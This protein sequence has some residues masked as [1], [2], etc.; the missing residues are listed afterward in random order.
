MIANA[1]KFQGMV[2][3]RN[4][5]YNDLHEFNIGGFTISSKTYVELLGIEIDFKLNFNKYLAKICKKAGG[6]LNTICRYNKFIDL[7]EK[8]TLIESFVQSNFNFCPLVWM[9]TSLKSVRKIEAVQKRALRILLNDYTSDYNTLLNMSK[10][11]NVVT[12]IHRILAR[13]VFKTLNDCNPEY[14][15]TIFVKNLR[16]NSRRPNDLQRQGFRG[17]T[18]G[19]NSLREVGA[20]I[21]NKLPENFK[22]A[23]SLIN[24]KNLIKTWSD[25][26]CSCKMCKAVGNKN[27][28]I[29]DED[30]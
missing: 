24:F 5:R 1:K 3:N 8:R 14:M 17:I 20:Q 13:E 9:F 27:D 28:P 29:D 15:K 22:S 26:R 16:E 25:F 7:E 19:Q 2:L 21:W 18:Y 10:K 12:R 23:P 11:S 6:Q 4:G 30:D